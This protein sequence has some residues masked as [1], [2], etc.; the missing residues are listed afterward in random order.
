MHVFDLHKLKVLFQAT[1][2][3]D[4]VNSKSDCKLHFIYT[5][6]VG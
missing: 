3:C 1:S 2:T 5:V 6:V 4:A